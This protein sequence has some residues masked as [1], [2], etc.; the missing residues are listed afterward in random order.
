MPPYSSSSISPAFCFFSVCFI[1]CCCSFFLITS[2]NSLIQSSNQQHLNSRGG[3][4]S[5]PSEA[6]LDNV[7][8]STGNFEL[9]EDQNQNVRLLKLFGGNDDAVSAGGTLHGTA[10]GGATR[11][12]QQLGGD[13]VTYGIGSSAPLQRLDP[14]GNQKQLFI[15]GGGAPFGNSDVASGFSSQQPD[16]R[17]PQQIQ[18]LHT[19]F[20]QKEDDGT[21][22]STGS[23][24]LENIFDRWSPFRPTTSEATTGNSAERPSTNGRGSSSSSQLPKDISSNKNQLPA[25]TGRFNKNFQVLDSSHQGLTNAFKQAVSDYR[26]QEQKQQ[27]SA[28]DNTNKSSPNSRGVPAPPQKSTQSGSAPSSSAGLPTVLQQLGGGGG[29]HFRT[30]AG[31]S[32]QQ[33]LPP[34]IQQQQQLQQ[35]LQQQLFSQQQT[36]TGASPFGGGIGGL[37]N[38]GLPPSPV[39]GG[40]VVDPSAFVIP[41]GTSPFSLTGNRPPISPSSSQSSPSS[42]SKFNSPPPLFP[43][44]GNLA[45]K[46]L[47]KNSAGVGSPASRNPKNSKHSSLE[48]QL[49]Q[50]LQALLVKGGPPPITGS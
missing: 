33:N 26:E 43:A 18:R 13:V 44:G 35:F 20:S 39:P 6:S 10:A 9:Q 12:Q 27:K 32:Q 23:D 45:A 50:Q 41:S 28:V 29:A 17:V 34:F 47:Q 1:T 31:G 8:P 25:S 49:Q 4:G 42:S 30:I 15:R 48:Q 3:I 24:P 37:A 22:P 40:R 19:A 11:Y 5:S 2:C 21:S 36:A 46:A 14:S 16:K 38:G 7:V